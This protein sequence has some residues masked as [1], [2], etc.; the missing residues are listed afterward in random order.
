[1]ATDNPLLK[2]TPEKFEKYVRGIVKREKMILQDFEVTHLELVEGMDGEYKMDV[3]ATFVL[4][5]GAIYRTLIE[6]KRYSNPI[7]REVVMILEQKLLSTGSHKGMI[8]STSHFQSG[9]VEF[10]KSH[11]I[12]LVYVQWGKK[13]VFV[14]NERNRSRV[15][16][17]T[18]E[19]NLLESWTAELMTQKGREPF[20][21]LGR[22]DV[23]PGENLLAYFGLNSAGK[24]TS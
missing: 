5:G 11:G 20:P 23:F 15:H 10:A 8:F 12:A 21:Y 1:M 4:F 3:V 19:E 14:T 9:A 18:E 7:E 17:M 2:M 22:P 13:R 16:E 6:C 24:S